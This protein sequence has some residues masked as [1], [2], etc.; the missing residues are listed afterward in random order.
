MK[1]RLHRLPLRHVFFVVV[2]KARAWEPEAP[3]ATVELVRAEIAADDVSGAFKRRSPVHN[4]MVGNNGHLSGLSP[5]RQ[6]PKRTILSACCSAAATTFSHDCLPGGAVP[7]G[8]LGWRRCD[9]EGRVQGTARG[10][11]S[12]S[13]RRPSQGDASTT[14]GADPSRCASASRASAD[15]HAG[16]ARRPGPPPAGPILGRRHN[17]RSVALAPKGARGFS[18][19]ISREAPG[20]LG[21]PRRPSGPRSRLVSS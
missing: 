10:A 11:P 1:E 3:H 8:E 14:A 13:C 16:R 18:G 7:V 19:G 21:R 20:P 15:R 12:F 5:K 4:S 9:Q 6:T 2:V 17:S